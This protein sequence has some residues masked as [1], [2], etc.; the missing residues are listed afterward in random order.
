MTNLVVSARVENVFLE[1]YCNC[2]NFQV[3]IYIKCR[4]KK[5][6]FSIV[7]FFVFAIKQ[8][9]QQTVLILDFY[10]EFNFFLLLHLIAV[11]KSVA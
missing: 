1:K 2:C 9:F 10:F 7:T 8:T 3:T 4:E 5:V 6:V 11:M